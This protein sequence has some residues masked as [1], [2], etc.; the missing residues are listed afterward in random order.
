MERSWGGGVHD[1]L[2]GG[3]SKR[4]A[5]EQ[6]VTGGK[7]GGGGDTMLGVGGWKKG[8]LALVIAG[9][10][11]EERVTGEPVN[12]GGVSGET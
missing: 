4:G 12:E 2:K 8:F 6:R 3:D 1:P 5:G 11:E 7:G 10:M 9:G